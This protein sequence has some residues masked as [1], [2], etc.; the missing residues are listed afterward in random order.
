MRLVACLF[1]ND[2]R[3]NMG[4][5]LM[6]SIWA[7]ALS[8]AVAME[9]RAQNAGS[10]F[11]YQGRLVKSGSVVDASCD[12]E[13]GLWDA[14]VGG[15]PIGASPQLVAGVAVSD[16]LFTVVLDFDTGAFDGDA[17]WLEITVQCPSDFAPIV[18]SPRQ[19]LTPAPYAIFSTAPWVTTGSDLTYQTGNVGIGIAAPQESLDVAGNFHA[20]GTIASGASITIDGTINTI[21]SDANLELHVA[22]GRALRI[23]S[24]SVSPNVISGNPQNSV[25]PSVHGAAIAGGGGSSGD[26]NRVTDNYGTVGGGLGNRAGN[27]S[28][29]TS[30]AEYATVCGG[31]SNSA[32]G[33]LSS[34]LGGSG[35]NATGNHATICGGAGNSVSGIRAVVCGGVGNSASGNHSAVLG[36]QT[37]EAPGD[38]SLAMGNRAKALHS[39]SFVWADFTNADFSSTGTNQF[40]IRASGGV[41]IGTNAP[42]E[43]L[44][45]NGTAR[46]TGFELP[47]GAAAGRVLTSDAA[48]TG[49]WQTPPTPSNDWTT[50]GNAGTNSATNFIGTTDNQAL[51]LRTNSVNRMTVTSSGFVGIGTTAPASSLEVV[52][53]SSVR[54]GVF[55]VSATGTTRAARL[56]QNQGGLAPA[57]Q[58]TQDTANSS[59]SWDFGVN[60][61]GTLFMAHPGSP[62]VF[63]L[64]TDGKLGLNSAFP[65]HPF[66]VGIDASNGNGAFC[67]AGGTWTNVCDRDKKTDF[68]TIDTREVLARLSQMPIGEWRYIGERRTVR[69]VGP[70]AQDFHAAFGLGESD[71]HIGTVDADGIALAAIQGLNEV[72]QDSDCEIAELRSEIED[73]RAIVNHLMLESKGGPR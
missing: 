56:V 51:S 15:N 26:V 50:T 68:A 9:S 4:R 43:E 13:F 16:G 3:V 70:V 53:T 18:L 22:S 40:L 20:S 72:V 60:T 47:T 59:L 57:L 35:N 33:P 62:A 73:L 32:A 69:H 29:T 66:Q 10:A 19:E 71:K 6:V 63:N 38:V 34:I 14:D 7:L 1:I 64:T 58:L 45:V 39:G 12:F 42:T 41:G 36:G 8:F 21:S 17:R 65:T 31:H 25:T 11:T 44:E 67:T 24:S 61:L 52:G 48:G 2:G 46:M 30:D 28:G 54:D 37:N 55:Q 5:P 49:T 27:F 23:E